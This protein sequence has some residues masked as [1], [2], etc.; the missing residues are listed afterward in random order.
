MCFSMLS[1]H[2]LESVHLFLIPSGF[3][4]QF[5]A[6]DQ[7]FC[8]LKSIPKHLNLPHLWFLVSYI[9]EAVLVIPD[10]SC[11]VN[12]WVIYFPRNLSFE[13]SQPTITFCNA[14]S[15]LPYKMM[16]HIWVLIL[17]ERLRWYVSFNTE[18]AFV[19]MHNFTSHSELRK[20]INW[21]EIYT[22]VHLKINIFL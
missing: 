11:N 6:G 22:R 13:Y 8:P 10:T 17:S 7:I 15:S 4:Q 3:I 18:K 2:N 14:Q 20:C 5:P 21:W 16:A 1:N 9:I 19:Y 12:N